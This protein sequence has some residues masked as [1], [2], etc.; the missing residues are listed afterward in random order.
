MKI[1]KN[2]RQKKKMIRI[3]IGNTQ[4]GAT[5]ITKPIKTISLTE[6]TVKEVYQKIMETLQ[7]ER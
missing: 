4:T 6:T 5:S 1:L 2:P 7:N 3:L